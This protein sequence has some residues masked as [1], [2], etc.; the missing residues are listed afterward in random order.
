M[1]FF[2]FPIAAAMSPPLAEDED[3]SED[4]AARSPVMRWKCSACGE[5]NTVKMPPKVRLVRRSSATEAFRAACYGT[6]RDM[7]SAGREA[8]QVFRESYQH[9]EDRALWRE[10]V[11]QHSQ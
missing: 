8:V 6:D 1:S 5:S 2:N 4:E 7:P 11:K 9:H 3:E 10:C